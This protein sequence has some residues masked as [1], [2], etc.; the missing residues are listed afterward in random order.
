MYIIVNLQC[1]EYEYPGHP[2]SPQRVTETF[3]FLEQRNISFIGPA[4]AQEED[5]LLAHSKSLL[6]KVKE[7]SFLDADTPALT[8][9]Y[10]YAK[11]SAGGAI[12]AAEL[13]RAGKPA[14]SLMRPPGHHATKEKLGGFCYFNNIA[15]AVKKLQRKACR[16]AILDIDCHHGNGT[17]DIFFGD[18][19]TLYVSL[20]QTPLYP[21]TGQVSRGNC[22]NFPLA[23]GIAEP[24]YLNI[25]DKAM[26]EIANFSPEVIAVSCG[27]DTYE[28]DPLCGLKL[29]Q[30]TYKKIAEKI[31]ALRVPI[32]SVLEGGY[33]PDLKYCIWEYV[34]GIG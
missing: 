10:E 30:K 7:G 21:G 32:F 22:L 25:L 16:T 20:H 23:A 15:I 14:F 29:K 28:H 12:C 6:N 2:E 9:I 17:E 24:L 5:I 34:Q 26:G 18:K 27:F 1:A 11:L 31:S 8:N 3:K 33:S 4:P 13:A 19:N